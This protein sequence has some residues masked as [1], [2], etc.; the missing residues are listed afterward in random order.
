MKLRAI[1]FF[2]TDLPHSLGLLRHG[3]WRHTSTHRAER[4]RPES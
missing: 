3:H 4:D 2:Y 1:T